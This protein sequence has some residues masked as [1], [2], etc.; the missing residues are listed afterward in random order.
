MHQKNT[1]HLPSFIV[2][3]DEWIGN[4]L[5][6]SFLFLFS[7]ERLSKLSHNSEVEEGTSSSLVKV[8]MKT[9]G[10]WTGTYLMTRVCVGKE[11]YSYFIIWLSCVNV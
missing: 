6:H 4:G 1:P 3:S 5:K 8:P 2:L 7:K 11:K 9:N 10:S